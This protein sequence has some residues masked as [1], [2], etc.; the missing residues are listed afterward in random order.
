MALTVKQVTDMISGMRR[1]TLDEN[2]A[3]LMTRVEQSFGTLDKDGS[4]YLDMEES[5][6][7]INDLFNMMH[8]PPP[9]RE[10]AEECFRGLDSDK[11]G[12]LSKSE[13]AEGIKA[14]L[15][16]KISYYESMLQYAN[17]KKLGPDDVIQ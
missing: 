15:R 13:M 4:G 5:I 7:L 14:A 3:E 11:S 16:I 17:E 1:L 10:Q 12:H 8:F 6:Q 9:P 2:Q